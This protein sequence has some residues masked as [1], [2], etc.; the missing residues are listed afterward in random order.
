MPHVNTQFIEF[1]RK[2][3]PAGCR[4]PPKYSNYWFMALR[5]TS[6]YENAQE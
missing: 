6:T 4:A 1:V 3:K 5:G 2:H